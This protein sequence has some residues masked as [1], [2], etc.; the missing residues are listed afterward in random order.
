MSAE[1]EEMITDFGQ[2]RVFDRVVVRP[3]LWHDPALLPGHRYVLIKLQALE[4]VRKHGD[5]GTEDYGAGWELLPLP[6]CHF[7]TNARLLTP[8]AVRERRVFRIIEEDGVAE[9]SSTARPRE[10]VD[11]T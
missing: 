10:K 5:V 2:L 9:S 4:D 11:A 8:D 6:S 3:C 7:T 1:R